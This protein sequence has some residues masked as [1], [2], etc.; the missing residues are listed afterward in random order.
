MDRDDLEDILNTIKADDI[1][2][3]KIEFHDGDYIK[4]LEYHQIKV[5]KEDK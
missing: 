3:V 5:N 4:A 1:R 2:H